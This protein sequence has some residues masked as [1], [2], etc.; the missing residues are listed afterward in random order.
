MM[1]N[2]RFAPTIAV[3]AF[4]L[5]PVAEPMAAP[6]ADAM[7][8]RAIQKANNE[9][10]TAV[11]TGDAATI[12]A[13]YAD[14]AVFVLPDGTCIQGRNEIE[15]MYRTSFEQSGLASSSRINST[16][17]VLD[18]DLAYELGNAEIGMLRGGKLS[19]NVSRYLTVWQRDSN[20]DW[21]ILRNLVLP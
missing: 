14:R 13:P 6:S 5:F 15:K 11:K 17:V 16:N 8:D 18:R 3:I 12:A 2:V 4:V 20:G 19:S 1:N 7:L 21:K 10:L 9:F